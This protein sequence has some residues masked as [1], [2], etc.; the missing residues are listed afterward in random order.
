MTNECLYCLFPIHTLDA[1]SHARPR[2]LNFVQPITRY[3]K[4]IILQKVSDGQFDT[5]VIEDFK[6]CIGVGLTT[7]C[8]DNNLYLTLNIV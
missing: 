4:Q 7:H 5:T 2:I 6:Y 8:N 1:A 3:A